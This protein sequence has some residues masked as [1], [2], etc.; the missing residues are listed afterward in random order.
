MYR[1]GTE[2]DRTQ[3][4]TYAPCACSWPAIDFDRRQPVSWSEPRE[5][6]TLAWANGGAECAPRNRG[7]HAVRRAGYELDDTS[8]YASYA[9]VFQPQSSYATSSAP[10]AEIGDTTSGHQGEWFDGP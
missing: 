9:D 4:G 2:G 6:N 10:Q 5:S 7:S 1:G 8:V 3:D